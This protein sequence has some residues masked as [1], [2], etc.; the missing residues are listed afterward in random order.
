M[1]EPR[2]FQIGE[3]VAVRSRWNKNKYFLGEISNYDIERGKYSVDVYPLKRHEYY[4]EP[5]IISPTDWLLK[6][7]EKNNGVYDVP[8]GSPTEDRGG[9]R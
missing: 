5:Q 2:I 8:I 7:L 3:K 9:T 4:A 6:E 1:S